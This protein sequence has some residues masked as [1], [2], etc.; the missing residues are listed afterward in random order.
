MP[1]RY[2]RAAAR[3]GPSVT[4]RELCLRSCAGGAVVTGPTRSWSW[5]TASMRL[6]SEVPRPC[7]PAAPLP[8]AQAPEVAPDLPRV[9][10]AAGLVH[11]RAPDQAVLVAG[12]RHPLGQHVVGVGQAGRAVGAAQVRELDAVL[13][14]QLARLGDERDNRLVGVDEVGVAVAPPP[15]AQEAEVAVHRPLLVVDAAAQELAGA[16]LGAALAPGV[17]AHE[18]GLA[19]R[20]ARAAPLE[21]VVD[22]RDQHLGQQRADDDAGGAE[23]EQHRPMTLVTA[24]RRPRGGRRS[25]ARRGAGSRRTT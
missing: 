2:A 11:V 10:L 7:T 24:R 8:L 18:A 4:W 22:A 3:L 16:L 15:H 12:Q 25:P 21:Q 5:A 23:R 13:V 1:L 14:E 17:V 9:D 20:P 6:A 19:P